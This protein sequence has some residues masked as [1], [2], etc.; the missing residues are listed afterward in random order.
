MT[1][2]NSIP[3]KS[4]EQLVS[5]FQVLDLVVKVLSQ[6]HAGADETSVRR[7][8]TLIQERFAKCEKALESLPGGNLTKD[9]QHAEI[10][11]LREELKRKRALVAKYK[12]H[13]VISRVLAQ[14]AI[15]VHGKEDE[16][17]EG[18]EDAPHDAGEPEDVLMGLDM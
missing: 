1:P 13:D 5:T 16:D 2:E 12:Q 3:T 15:P 10:K 8:M 11:R 17:E 18:L 4:P 7:T 9:D 14:R 6:I